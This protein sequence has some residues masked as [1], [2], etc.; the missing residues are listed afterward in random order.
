ME[1]LPRERRKK[2]GLK[3][4]KLSPHLKVA[5]NSPAEVAARSLVVPWTHKSSVEAIY[6]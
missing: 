3:W 1:V 6:R 5:W 4:P 2:L